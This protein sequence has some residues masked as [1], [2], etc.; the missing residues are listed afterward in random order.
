LEEPNVA[1]DIGEGVLGLGVSEA[2]LKIRNTRKAPRDLVFGREL[3][4]DPKLENFRLAFKLVIVLTVV[5]KRETGDVYL[6]A[7]IVLTDALG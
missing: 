3:G 7:I 4:R 1:A 5:G 2:E 6:P